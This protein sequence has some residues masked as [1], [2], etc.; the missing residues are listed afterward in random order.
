MNLILALFTFWSLQATATQTCS[1]TWVYQ[2]YQTCGL[3]GASEACGLKPIWNLVR[4]AKPSDGR[5]ACLSCDGLEKGGPL[6]LISCLKAS[7]TN[8]L[9]SEAVKSGQVQVRPEDVD[10]VAAQVVN[11]LNFHMRAFQ[12]EEEVRV[13]TDFL[14]KYGSRKSI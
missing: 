12:N 10:G 11:V 6:P 13:F 5:T 14:K 8:V 3:G 9:N 7:I 2:P 4:G 1:T